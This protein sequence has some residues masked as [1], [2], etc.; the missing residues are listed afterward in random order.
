MKQ[1]DQSNADWWEKSSGRLY[2]NS[3]GKTKVR[4]VKFI[5]KIEDLLPGTKKILSHPVWNI[6]SNPEASL[7]EL[8]SYMRAF[9]IDMQTKLFKVEKETNNYQRIKIKSITVDYLSK[10]NNLDALACLLMMIREAEITKQI[11]AYIS[12]KWRVHH[13]FCRLATFQPLKSM[14]NI[15]YDLIFDH[16]IY[17]NDPLPKSLSNVIVENRPHIYQIPQKYPIPKFLNE[18]LEII[19]LA[20]EH[21]VIGDS[22]EEKLEFL[23][24]IDFEFQRKDIFH[25]L[26]SISLPHLSAKETPLMPLTEIKERISGNSRKYL[27]SGKYFF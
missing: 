21:H 1:D 7:F 3:N 4:D 17:K 27:P 6:L 25:A 26:L 22:L 2:K 5:N 18:N 8:Y 9:P 14:A 11:D 15:I 24:W 13:L 19:S 16:F 23:F 10:R 20:I 12:C